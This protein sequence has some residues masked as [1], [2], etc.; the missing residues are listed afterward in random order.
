MFDTDKTRMIGLPYGEKKTMTIRKPFSYNTGTLRT[1]GWTDKQTDTWTG[2]L[3][4]YRASIKNKKACCSRDVLVLVVHG[5][6]VVVIYC[7]RCGIV[8]AVTASLIPFT[9]DVSVHIACM[10]FWWTFEHVVPRLFSLP[11]SMSL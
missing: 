9:T 3:Y 8:Y 4:Q 11:L 1:D 10:R 7:C 6:L 5:S 2:L